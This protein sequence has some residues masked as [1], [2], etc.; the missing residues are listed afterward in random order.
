MTAY[1]RPPTALLSSASRS[2]T[3]NLAM[4]SDISADSNL[5]RASKSSN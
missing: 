1:R 2:S 4:D 3:S 5:L